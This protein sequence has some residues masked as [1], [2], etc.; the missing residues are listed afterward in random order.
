[1]TT[2]GDARTPSALEPMFADR[3]F[4]LAVLMRAGAD[5][6]GEIA[7]STDYEWTYDHRPGGE[8]CAYLR[9]GDDRYKV[10]IEAR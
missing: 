2:D 6:V 3:V 4:V 10:T 8:T 5:V 1:M 7:P 9:I